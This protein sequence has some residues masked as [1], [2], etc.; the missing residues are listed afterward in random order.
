MGTIGTPPPRGHT[1]RQAAGPAAGGVERPV[2]V[3][4]HRETD[5]RDHVPVEVLFHARR[6]RDHVHG[7][8]C[9]AHIY[10]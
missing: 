9:T 10:Y 4:R 5:G 6:S 3:R 7:L 2:A 8:E 1:S